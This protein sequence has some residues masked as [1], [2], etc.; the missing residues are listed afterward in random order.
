[1]EDHARF[2]D[3]A[4][5]SRRWV[6]NHAQVGRTLRDAVKEIVREWSEVSSSVTPF[7]SL[8]T[9]RSL[10][11]HCVKNPPSCDPW[12][13]V[14]HA[15]AGAEQLAWRDVILKELHDMRSDV[16][17]LEAKMKQEMGILSRALLWCEHVVKVMQ[18]CVV[19]GHQAWSTS[20]ALEGVW[21]TTA[22]QANQ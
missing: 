8:N 10:L 6:E 5:S 1:M 18:E 4:G 12:R 7:P 11:P 20:G 2:G 22:W 15:V 16:S 13:R 3:D 21:A 17:V 14:L 19:M 9:V